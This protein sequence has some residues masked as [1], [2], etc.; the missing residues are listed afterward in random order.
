MNDFLKKPLVKV[1]MLKGEKGET[2]DVSK[3]NF[4]KSI[5]DLTDLISNNRSS[6]DNANSRIKTTNSRIDNLIVSS[7]SDSSAEVIDARTGYNGTAYETLG[8]A[9]R[10]QVANKR[11]F[12]YNLIS[13]LK[14]GFTYKE[15]ALV[16]AS[17]RAFT[18]KLYPMHKDDYINIKFTHNDY[19]VLIV[20]YDNEMNALD[21][22]ET[23]W[24]NTLTTSDYDIQPF[25]GYIGFLLKQ[26]NDLELETYTGNAIKDTVFI[27]LNTS[28]ELNEWIKEIYTFSVLQG[29]GGSVSI[30][31]DERYIRTGFCEVNEGDIINVNI[32]V[33]GIA[34]LSN[35]R[36][37]AGFADKN[38]ESFTGWLMCREKYENTYVKEG[39][40]VLTKLSDYQITIPKGTNYIM[41]ESEYS[42][43]GISQYLG[44]K[45]GHIDISDK[46]TYV[47]FAL[48]DETGIMS[49]I[50]TPKRKTILFD[51]GQVE[52]TVRD[53]FWQ[54]CQDN[55]LIMRLDYVV[56]TH[57]HSDHVG[58][59][60]YL[61]DRMHLIDKDT[62]VIIPKALS[63]SQLTELKNFDSETYNDY[64]N[65]NN[66]ISQYQCKTVVPT[67]F[68]DIVVDNVTL[69]FF[70]TNLDKY[71]NP[72]TDYNLTSL[73][74]YAIIDNTTICYASDA[75]NTAY[76]D[77]VTN[78]RKS[79]ILVTPHHGAGY[80]FTTNK[81]IVDVWFPDLLVTS[82]GKNVLSAI[83]TDN[84]YHVW[85]VDNRI[86]DYITGFNGHNIVFDIG[87]SG[88]R[89]VS[90]SRPK[91][92][93]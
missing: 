87:K 91:T 48:A 37:I 8:K 46:G 27:T 66:L 1:L 61:H 3:E 52:Q 64:I 5:N 89:L 88:Y 49:L 54:M 40:N 73:C 58:N 2:G 39:D 93:K 65:T 41:I 75:Y 53:N 22:D 47:G 71:F 26:V 77:Y 59:F 62:T 83:T 84:N 19:R 24:Q 18:P 50:V 29:N 32:A 78:G 15:K 81:E 56:I 55:G 92:S 79:N 36:G 7:G 63:D 67:E 21:S 70:N 35:I 11:A 9:I 38:L 23:M 60:Q 13:E 16:K 76:D 25:D 31:D 85:A 86:P 20:R 14:M 69:E 80:N 12:T 28:H 4:D 72:L 68:Q 44:K 34:S 43:C 51:T 90:K 82:L 45:V 33:S 17:N 74:C 6:I 30:V 42:Y 10:T 57:Y